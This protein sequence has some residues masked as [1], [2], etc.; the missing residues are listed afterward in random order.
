MARPLA[1]AF[2]AAA[3]RALLVPYLTAGWPALAATPDLLM[4]LERG[5]ADIIEIGVP[6]S[7]PSADGPVIQ[8]ANEQAIANGVSVAHALAATRS[9]RVAGGQLPVV[10][11]GYANPFLRYG[12]DELAAACTE[13]GVAGILAVDWPP[14]PADGLAGPLAAALVDRIV[15]IA[16]TTSAARA[17][18]LAAAGSGYAY[19]VSMQGVTGALQLDTAAVAATAEQVRSATGLP[20]AVGFGVR[21]PEDCRVL[22]AAFDAVIV[23]TRLLEEIQAAS[24]QSG[25]AEQLLSSMREALA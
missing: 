12:I 23:G 18:Q 15:L 19:Y 16:P 6:F 22:G 17:A 24:D 13:C 21:T 5:G 14:S 1:C 9:Y 20:V 25:A 4:A 11:M 8:R 7:D 10:L 2:A 3:G